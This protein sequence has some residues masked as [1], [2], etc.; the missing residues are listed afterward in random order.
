ME[1]L[2]QRVRD[3]CGDIGYRAQKWN[4]VITH[5]KS[6]W[7][8]YFNPYHADARSTKVG[9]ARS[10]EKVTIH[11]RLCHFPVLKETLCAVTAQMAQGYA[12]PHLIALFIRERRKDFTDEEPYQM[13]TPNIRVG[14]TY[15]LLRLTR[16]NMMIICR[17]DP[18]KAY[19]AYYILQRLSYP[20]SRCA[21]CC[22]SVNSRSLRVILSIIQLPKIPLRLYRRKILVIDHHMMILLLPW[23]PNIQLLHHHLSDEDLMPLHL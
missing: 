17:Q 3:G 20:L 2:P 19:Y 18:G 4:S 10:T 1:E 16:E 5:F 11:P 7:K 8:N 6:H 15:I 21:F 12:S 22:F 14:R 9:D 13:K 23:T